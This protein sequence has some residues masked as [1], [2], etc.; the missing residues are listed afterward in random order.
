MR[1]VRKP[2]RRLDDVMLMGAREVRC[3]VVSW[4]VEGGGG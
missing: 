1:R 4:Q 3:E 2:R